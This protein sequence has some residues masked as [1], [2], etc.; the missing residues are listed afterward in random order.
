V[1]VPEITPN[2][3]AAVSLLPELLAEGEPLLTH[4]NVVLEA[5]FL[6][7]ARLG[8]RAAAGFASDCSAFHLERVD[9]ELHTSAL[10]K[11]SKSGKRH[12]SLV[13]QDSFLV[14]ERRNLK[15]AFAFDPDFKAAVSSC[16]Q[17]I[18][19]RTSNFELIVR[20]RI[21]DGVSFKLVRC[22]YQLCSLFKHKTGGPGFSANA[23]TRS[24][25]NSRNP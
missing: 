8:M 17:L 7:Q 23:E 6:P 5:V 20:R 14:M 12:L 1:S 2:H 13:D 15:S 24:A 10:R 3:R 18:C 9:S 25:K 11:W 4:N 22:Y 21:D 19:G 16:M